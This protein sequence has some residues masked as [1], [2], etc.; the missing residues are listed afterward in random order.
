MER[1]SHTQFGTLLCDRWVKHNDS[2][3]RG[4][5][6][7]LGTSEKNGLARH[8]KGRLATFD[9]D[10]AKLDAESVDLIETRS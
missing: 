10:I 5:T 8:H 2:V 4:A 9:R 1:K 6:C 7:R 3:S